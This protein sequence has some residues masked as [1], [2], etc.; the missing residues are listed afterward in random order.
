MFEFLGAADIA[1]TDPETGLP[2]LL[3]T[4][5]ARRIARVMMAAYFS[6]ILSTADSCLMASPGMWLPISSGGSH[7]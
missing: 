5:L 3:R 4:V 1:D 7:R 2:M 6:A